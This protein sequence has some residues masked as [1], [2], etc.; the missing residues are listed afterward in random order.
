LY[1]YCY[2][3]AQKPSLY[4]PPHFLAIFTNCKHPTNMDDQ[5][6][7]AASDYFGAIAHMVREEATLQSVRDEVRLA[8]L[9][10]GSIL[11]RLETL[12][13]S[14]D[15]LDAVRGQAECITFEVDGLVVLLRGLMDH[16]K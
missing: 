13:P 8:R 16:E 12:Q 6:M 15:D 14:R 7:M 5:D 2:R 9:K 11:D 10:L 3:F 4:L 1:Q